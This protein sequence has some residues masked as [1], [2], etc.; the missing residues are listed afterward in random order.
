MK[1]KTPNGASELEK[2]TS[3]QGPDVAVVADQVTGVAHAVDD[4]ADRLTTLECSNSAYQ[5]PSQAV[6]EMG[7]EDIDSRLHNLRTAD[8]REAKRREEIA[9]LERKRAEIESQNLAHQVREEYDRLKDEYLHV[10]GEAR[11]VEDP[12]E[13][14]LIAFL[15]AGQRLAEDI[16][17]QQESK[18]FSLMRMREAYPELRLPNA[19]PPLLAG[20]LFKLCL[21]L[22]IRRRAVAGKRTRLPVADFHCPVTLTKP[23]AAP[24]TPDTLQL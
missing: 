15:T 6:D 4:L 17:Q 7:L 21:D 5:S 10:R 14:E 18:H 20:A 13:A 8:E 1:R 12:W 11:A 2:S 23:G 22:V 19:P 24:C 16:A 3:G 9:A